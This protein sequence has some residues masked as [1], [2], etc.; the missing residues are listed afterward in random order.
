MQ[1][2]PKHADYIADSFIQ[3]MRNFAS[4]NLVHSK[5]EM[6]K[7]HSSEHIPARCGFSWR[8]RVGDAKTCG[9]LRDIVNSDLR[10]IL[11]RS[12]ACSERD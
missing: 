1:T 2:T 8:E 6:R 12:S 11:F 3:R 7:W 4:L 5:S 9:E 10:E